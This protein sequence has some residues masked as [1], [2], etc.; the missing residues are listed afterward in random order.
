MTNA[1]IAGFARSP[2]HFAGKGGL[3]R[4]RPDDMAAQVVRA[5][6]SRT[7]VKPEDIEDIIVDA[8]DPHG[9]RA[10]RPGCR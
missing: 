4:V 10:D 7:G 8:V 9:G 1:V 6:I 3:V 5:L 2:F